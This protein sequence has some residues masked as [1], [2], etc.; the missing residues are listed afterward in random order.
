MCKGELGAVD[1]LLE[2]STGA[3]LSTVEGGLETGLLVALLGVDE[4]LAGTMEGNDKEEGED[5]GRKESTQ[6]FH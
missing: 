4:V 1:E 3:I 5:K 6:R 2:G